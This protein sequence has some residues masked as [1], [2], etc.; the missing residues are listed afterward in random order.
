MS[1]KGGFEEHSMQELLTLAQGSV[2]DSKLVANLTSKVAISGVE[3]VTLTSNGDK[4]VR[5]DSK[6]L[7]CDFCP[8]KTTQK[9]YL[10][11]HSH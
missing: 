11:K 9:S 8:L 3:G 1:R 5:E 10:K 4:H 6:E 7:K 2:G